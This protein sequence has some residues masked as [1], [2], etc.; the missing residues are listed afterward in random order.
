MRL[1]KQQFLALQNL[2]TNKNIVNVDINKSLIVSS[3]REKL[4]KKMHPSFE[5]GNGDSSKKFYGIITDNQIWN[6][7]LQK[8]FKDFHS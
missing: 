8:Y 1:S 4:S 2:R 5:F 3:I 6:I 7:S